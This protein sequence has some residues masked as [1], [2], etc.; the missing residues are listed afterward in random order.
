MSVRVVLFEDNNR[1]REQICSLIQAYDEFVVAGAFPDC[2]DAAHIIHSI[3]PDVVI[4]DIDMPYKNGIEGVKEI[5]STRPE[6]L[7]IMHTVFEEDEKLF[8]CLRAGASG[9][10]LKKT[11]PEDFIEALHDVTKGGAPMSPSIAKKVIDSF[12][13]T[14]ESNI[15]YDLTKREL[16]VLEMLVKGYSYKMIA[17]ESFIT[18][19]T[20]KSH[21]KNIYIKLHVNSGKEAVAKALRDQIV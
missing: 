14:K 3:Q 6:T 9:Y 15:N 21:L 2:R 1:L 12:R 10:L 17:A 13:K 8:E 19:E 16:E 7:I 18:T 11:S 4:M 20:V 5:K